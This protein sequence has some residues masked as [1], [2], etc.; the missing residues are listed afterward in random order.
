MLIT[1]LSGVKL[2]YL[3]GYSPDFNPIEEGFSAMKAWIRRRSSYVREALSNR[4]V[5]L[6]H[7]V[8]KKA[9]REAMVPEKIQGWFMHSGYL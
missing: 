2:V 7:C 6:A 4:D 3:P 8:L 9:A 1:R 5:C